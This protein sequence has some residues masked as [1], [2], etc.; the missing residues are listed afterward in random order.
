MRHNACCLGYHQQPG[1]L[2]LLLSLFF[3]YNLPLLSARP[4]WRTS[5]RRAE[6]KRPTR[7]F[8]SGCQ[9]LSRSEF[10]Y[11]MLGVD[12][13]S[14]QAV[15]ETKEQELRCT[16]CSWRSR[17]SRCWPRASSKCSSASTASNAVQL[18]PLRHRQRHRR[19]PASAQVAA[20]ARPGSPARWRIRMKHW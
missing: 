11:T 15:C 5:L 8:A 13:A 3:A 7:T 1:C 18:L 10:H 19:L 14:G 20:G 9:C 12:G 4:L 16:S 17:A 2:L 6:R